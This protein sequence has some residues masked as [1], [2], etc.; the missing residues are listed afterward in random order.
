MLVKFLLAT[1]VDPRFHNLKFLHEKLNSELKLEL[2]RLAT[3]FLN[4]YNQME[5]L[6]HHVRRQKQPLIYFLVRKKSSLIIVV[7]LN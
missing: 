5:R 4:Q 7:K 1:A 3:A 2:L 6:D